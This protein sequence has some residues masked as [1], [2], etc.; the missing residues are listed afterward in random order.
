M[1]KH[2]IWYMMKMSLTSWKKSILLTDREAFAGINDPVVAI[3][4]QVTYR[5]AVCKAKSS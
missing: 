2:I 1:L 4:R 5:A 3:T